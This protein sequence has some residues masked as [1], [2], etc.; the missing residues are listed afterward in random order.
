[1][2]GTNR[3]LDGRWLGYFRFSL[4]SSSNIRILLYSLSMK[5]I[6][7]LMAAVIAIATVLAAGLAALPSLTQNM[8]N[9]LPL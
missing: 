4:K 2:D 7:V 5:K 6:T 9:R 3:R 8:I 1:M